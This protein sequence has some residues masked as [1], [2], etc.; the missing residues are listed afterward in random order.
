[1]ALN[2]DASLVATVVASGTALVSAVIGYFYERGRARTVREEAGERVKS[3]E[4]VV[5]TGSGDRFFN[6]QRESVWRLRRSLE[7]AKVD[8][9]T[10]SSLLVRLDRMDSTLR[11]NSPTVDL[12]EFVTLEADVSQIVRESDG[13]T[14]PRPQSFN[15][16]LTSDSPPS[17][18]GRRLEP[19]PDD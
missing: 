17:D 1:M 18:L 12:T 13:S 9:V 14:Q 11:S 16:G 2:I 10:L 4:N 7:L 3:R 6:Y 8:P 15:S 5:Q 19:P